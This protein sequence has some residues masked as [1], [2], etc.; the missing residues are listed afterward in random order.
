MNLKIKIMKNQFKC[1]LQQSNT[2]IQ[3]VFSF[4]IEQD[5]IK[6]Y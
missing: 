2:I 4:Q 3:K 5:A 1:I 6:F